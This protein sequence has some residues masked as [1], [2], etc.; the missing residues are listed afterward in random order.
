MSVSSDLKEL[1]ISELHCKSVP[2]RVDGKVVEADGVSVEF[3]SKEFVIRACVVF[4]SEV[5]S[6]EPKVVGRF[7]CA[8]RWGSVLSDLSWVA[9]ELSV[10]RKQRGFGVPEVLFAFGDDTCFASPYEYGNDENIKLSAY[11]TVR[12]VN[13]DHVTYEEI[14]E[15][16]G[17]I[18]KFY[19]D[20]RKYLHPPEYFDTF[21]ES[22]LLRPISS[23]QWRPFNYL[24]K[25]ADYALVWVER[26]LVTE[27]K[28]PEVSQFF[29]IPYGKKKIVT[30]KWQVCT[31]RENLKTH[32]KLPS[33]IGIKDWEPNAECEED[34]D[35]G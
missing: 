20:Q 18:E 8:K 3:Q 22:Q 19:G 26:E 28:N 10:W 9:H 32:L 12:S 24:P 34:P 5:F 14:L 30:E 17:I 33:Y 21:S 23:E 27:L 11:Y 15:D 6:P 16:F 35:H 2:Y 7:P 4:H 13:S 1:Y 31:H 25:V 29:G